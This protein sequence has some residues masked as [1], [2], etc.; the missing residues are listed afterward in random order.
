MRYLLAV[1][2]ALLAGC[3]PK[4]VVIKIESSDGKRI[5]LP[6]NLGKI[7]PMVHVGDPTKEPGMTGGP[8]KDESCGHSGCD[9]ARKFVL[10]TKCVF[11]KQPLGWGKK[12][13]AVGDEGKSDRMVW[14][15]HCGETTLCAACEKPLG[16]R[17][18]SVAGGVVKHDVGF[19][20]K[21][22]APRGYFGQPSTQ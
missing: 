19:D 9:R 10:E 14:H 16:N 18:F 5:T 21:Q 1:A 2:F 13:R 4:E 7:S 17:K 15:D 11:C 3:G 8:C 20:C 22:L 12:I 6:A